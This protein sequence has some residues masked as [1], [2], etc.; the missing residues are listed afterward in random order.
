MQN[1]LQY[2]VTLSKSILV[3]AKECAYTLHRHT[4]TEEQHYTDTHTLFESPNKYRENLIKAP[5]RNWAILTALIHQQT[6][7]RSKVK[8]VVLFFALTELETFSEFLH[9][10]YFRPHF[11]LCCCEMK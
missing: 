7:M 10:L 11:S 6:M 8:C 2:A 1:V 9:I 4:H 3:S 5:M